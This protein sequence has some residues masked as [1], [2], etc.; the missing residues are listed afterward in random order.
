[1]QIEELLNKGYIF[2]SVSPW[3]APILFLKKK[4]ATLRICIDFRKLNKVTMKNKFPF[5]RIYD[6][7]Y[8]LR[9][10]RIFFKIN[11]RYGY[12]QI[13]IKEEDISETSFRTRYGNYVFIVVPFGLSK[14]TIFLHVFS[15]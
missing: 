7:F 9:G 3:G 6:L 5:P 2:P 10:A 14:A 15:E 12:H 1:M 11:L 13:R 8:H 4:D